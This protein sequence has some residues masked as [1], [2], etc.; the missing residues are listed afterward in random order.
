MTSGRATVRVGEVS[1]DPCFIHE[2]RCVHG[3]IPMGHGGV[4]G[5]LNVADKRVAQGAGL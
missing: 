4:C 5:S 1:A 2:V 3:K